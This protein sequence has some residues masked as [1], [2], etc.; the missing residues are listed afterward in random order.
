MYI[1]FDDDDNVIDHVS[2]IVYRGKYESICVAR[3]LS[4]I[5]VSFQVGRDC[6]NI[7]SFYYYRV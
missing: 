6:S 7:S 2:C 5:R 1:I 4:E 3:S